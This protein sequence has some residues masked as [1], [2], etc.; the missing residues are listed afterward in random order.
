MVKVGFIQKS[1]ITAVR[2]KF[3]GETGYFYLKKYESYRAAFV[4]ACILS[5]VILSIF[6]TP[7]HFG[8]AETEAT[9]QSTQPS[10]LTLTS[11]TDTATVSINPTVSGTFGKST[12]ANSIQFNISTNN[13]SGYTL[14]ARTT[15]TTLINGSSSLTSLA[16]AVS[17][18]QFSSAGNTTLNNRWGYKPNYYNSS[19]NSNFLPSPGSSSST[20]DHTSAANSTA[21]NYTI[22]LGARVNTEVPAGTYVNDTLVLEATA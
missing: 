17:E 2:E 22:V 14:T 10:T 20:L 11:A 21:K 8:G 15:R 9:S 13:Y 16:S 1:L 4:A 3:F 7:L 19:S 6:I 18:S 5:F 12:D